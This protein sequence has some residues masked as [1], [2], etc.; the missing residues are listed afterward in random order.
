MGE[1]DGGGLIEAV[2]CAAADLRGRGVTTLLFLPADVP[3]VSPDELEVVLEG[4]G[5]QSGQAEM[6]IVPA[7]DLGGS[8][9]LACSPPDAIAF[10]FGIDSFRRHL[11]TAE[12]SGIVP[13]VA[14]LPGLGLDLD[15]PDDLAQL[16]D[17]FESNDSLSSASITCRYLIES[18]IADRMAAS[19]QTLN[20]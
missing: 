15:T 7:S 2:T 4:F 19:P 18:G 5:R 1:P 3:L 16:I 17:R 12:E 8:N 13:T 11:R 9:C 6:T 20:A 14:R 10:G